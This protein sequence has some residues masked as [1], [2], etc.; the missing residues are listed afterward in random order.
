MLFEIS[1]Y[2]SPYYCYICTNYLYICLIVLYKMY[3]D[4][5]IKEMF[6]HN[7]I[8]VLLLTAITLYDLFFLLTSSCNS[9]E[10]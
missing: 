4:F 5:L 2:I 8:S 3:A 6:Y 10:N 1:I 9:L 7:R